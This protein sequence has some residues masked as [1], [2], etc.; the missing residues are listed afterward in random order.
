V[1]GKDGSADRLPDDVTLHVP[2]S[3]N[4]PPGNQATSPAWATNPLQRSQQC[5]LKYHG[6]AGRLYGDN[7]S[8]II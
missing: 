8:G 2:A 6:N 5:S 4:T 7:M 3:S 1:E